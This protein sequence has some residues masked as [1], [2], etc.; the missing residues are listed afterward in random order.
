MFEA[1]QTELH[2]DSH[3]VIAPA[4]R[5]VTL[6]T[7]KISDDTKAVC[8]DGVLVIERNDF[9]RHCLQRSIA[10][11]WHKPAEG[12]TALTNLKESLSNGGVSVAIL[13]I[14]SLNDDEIAAEYARL[15]DAE[16]RPPTMVLGKN[17]NLNSALQA[18]NHGA[19]GYIS[20]SAGFKIFI[21]ALKFVAAGGTY[22]PAQCLRHAERP[23]PAAAA[24]PDQVNLDILTSRELAVIEAIRRGKP[25]KVIAYELNMCESTVKVHVRHIMKK[26]QARNRTDVA[27]KSV[28]LSPS[29]QNDL[30]AQTTTT[31]KA[32]FV[33]LRNE[34]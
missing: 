2:G 10:E 23:T 21:E 19:N 30:R 15:S 6:D 18:L 11:S 7:S 33:V 16:G 5:V 25:N 9:M 3:L 13:S 20:I 34:L 22:V 12:C 14:L 27:I 24:A 4:S 8:A 32:P 17:D 29:H 26:L 1:T 31:D 28:T